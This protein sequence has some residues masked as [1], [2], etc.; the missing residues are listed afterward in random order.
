MVRSVKQG[1]V[2]MVDLSANSIGHEQTGVRPCLIVSTNSR[3]NTSPNVFIFPITHANKKYQPCH[4]LL[5]RND[6]QFFNYKKNYVIC[7][8]GRSISKNRLERYLGK[9]NECDLQK[10]IECKEYVFAEVLQTRKENNN[11]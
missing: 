1:D 11:E 10:I 2:Y 5:S 3:N 7:E 8:E 9:I 4:Y 6:Y